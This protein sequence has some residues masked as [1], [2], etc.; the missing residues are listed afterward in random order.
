M[1]FPSYL[2]TLKPFEP[3]NH[4]VCDSIPPGGHA[5]GTALMVTPML[6]EVVTFADWFGHP[7]NN[8]FDGVSLTSLPANLTNYNPATPMATCVSLKP[9]AP[10]AFLKLFLSASAAHGLTHFSSCSLAPV[11]VSLVW[12]L[13]LTMDCAPT[14]MKL[15]ED[16]VLLF[17]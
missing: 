1:Y 16:Q 8:I 2:F 12:H 7:D 5:P 13:L 6:D 9:M 14:L 11:L 4:H 3:T 17:S 15:R 10:L